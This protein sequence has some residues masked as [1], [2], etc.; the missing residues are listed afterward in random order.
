MVLSSVKQS[1][2]SKPKFILCTY[3]SGYF[4][5]STTN[6]EQNLLEGILLRKKSILIMEKKGE[7]ISFER[8]KLV[9]SNWNMK[10]S[11][12][13]FW[14]DKL[15]FPIFKFQFWRISFPESSF[16]FTIII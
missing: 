1:H 14:I 16:K 11:K 12:T 3:S 2:K 15:S 6:E 10:I 13:T 5:S 9:I 8:F 7:V 4:K